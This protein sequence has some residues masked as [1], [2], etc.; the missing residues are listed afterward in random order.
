MSEMENVNSIVEELRPDLKEMCRYIHDNPEL[1]LSE[2]KACRAQLELLKRHGFEI[3]EKFEGFD[4]AYKAVYRGGGG[5]PRIA[6]LSEYDALP[7]LGH[8]CGHNLIAMISVGSAIAMVPFADKYGGEICVIGTPAEETLGTKVNMARS[9]VFDDI[10]VVMMAHPS[11]I[12]VEAVDTMAINAYRFA[13]HGKATHAAGSP[14]NGVNALDAMISF[15]NMVNALRQQTR[16]D[17]RIAGIITEGGAAANIIPDYTEAIFNVRANRCGYLEVLSE[18]VIRCAEAAALGTG[19]TLDYGTP[20][21][22]GNFKDVHSNRALSDLQSEQ[23]EKLGV[24]VTRVGDMVAP[25]SSD[26]GDVSYICPSIQVAFDICEGKNYDAHT[27]E[28]AECA[29]SE[30]AMNRGLIYVRGFVLTAIELMTDPSRLEK[31]REEFSHINDM[32][33]IR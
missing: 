6:M 9:G 4:T 23:M 22:E 8:G 20:E 14:E 15:F 25:G 30:Q 2:F 1:G 5:G 24:H 31:I 19:A 12:D 29:G 13:F 32:G 28:F 3:E 18:K 10:D 7:G 27:L 16:P 11:F 26:L 33:M 21:G 17:A